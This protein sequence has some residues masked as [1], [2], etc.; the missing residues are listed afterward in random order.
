MNQKNQE[1]PD[2][3]NPAYLFRTD[4]TELLCKIVN[5][6]IDAVDLAKN[7]LRAR[8]RDANGAW[9]GFEIAAKIHETK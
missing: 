2:E 6:E 1:L 9:V 5:G 7:E 4:A 3:L 8:G